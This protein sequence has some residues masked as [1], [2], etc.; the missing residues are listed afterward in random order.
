MALTGMGDAAVSF[1]NVPVEAGGY[2]Q[3]RLPRQPVKVMRKRKNNMNIV[4]RKRETL[5]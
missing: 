2:C 5:M 1:R 3:F 4:R